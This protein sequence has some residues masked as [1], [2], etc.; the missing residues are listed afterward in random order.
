MPVNPLSADQVRRVISEGTLQCKTT[1]E[2][3]PLDQIIGQE[4]AVR[5]LEFG[6]GIQNPG[7]NVYVAGM[8]GTGRT[9]AV[10]G[11]LEEL[12]KDQSIPSDWAYVY[13]FADPYKP[14]AIKLPSGRG[15][16]FVEDL[17]KLFQTPSRHASLTTRL[18]AFRPSL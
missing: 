12:A 14:N 11:Y 7:Y 3:E 10:K 4:R 9:T 1:E 15:K 17:N 18:A 13:N 16:V 6:L 5:A 8:P 2:L